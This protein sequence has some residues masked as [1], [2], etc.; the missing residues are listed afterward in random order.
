LAFFP[1]LLFLIYFYL[2]FFLFFILSSF[3]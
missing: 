3:T 2:S 1:L